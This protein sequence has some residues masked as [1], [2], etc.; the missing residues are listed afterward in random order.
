MEYQIISTGSKGNAVI[1]ND[2][3]MIDCGVPF[4]ALRQVKNELKIVLLTHKHGDHFKESTIKALSAQRPT[5]RFACGEWLANRLEN[6]GIDNID[7]LQTGKKYDYGLFQ[8]AMVKLYHNVPNCGYRLFMNGEKCFYATDTNTLAGITARNYDLYMV[9]ANYE[10][11]EIQNRIRAKEEAG[12]YPYEYE[13]LQNHLSL[14]KANDFIYE[15]IG[16]KGRYV[17]LHGHEGD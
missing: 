3:I 7:I 11:E 6:I 8:V 14:K 17:F 4:K 9:E 2:I 10:D 5:L 1:V 16:E 12:K 15:N 13:V